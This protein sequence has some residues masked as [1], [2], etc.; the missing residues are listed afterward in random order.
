MCAQRHTHKQ[1]L[2][3]HPRRSFHLSP[4]L[5]PLP[6]PLSS[7]FLSPSITPYPA[8]TTPLLPP[9][10]PQASPPSPLSP[11]SPPSP[12]SSKHPD[13]QSS[14]SSLPPPVP[15]PPAPP[16]PRLLVCGFLSRDRLG[17]CRRTQGPCWSCCTRRRAPARGF[18]WGLG[19][20]SCGEVAAWVG[21]RRL[22]V[23]GIGI[24]VGVRGWV[25]VVGVVVVVGEEI[26]RG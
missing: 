18:L 1:H 4:S 11:L 16:Y 17:C 12:P 7:S 5:P 2:H 3:L 20:S 22:C 8:S 23:C 25:V 15:V 26:G 10:P 21:R 24:G 14:P 19:G 6:K 9:P 13:S